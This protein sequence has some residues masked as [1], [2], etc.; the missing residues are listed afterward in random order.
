MARRTIGLA[1][2]LLLAV[3]LTVSIPLGATAS[4]TI[5]LTRVSGANRFLT[6]VAISQAGFPTAGSAKVVVLASGAAFADALA[7]TPLAVQKGG[8]LLLTPN[9]GLSAPVAAEITRVLPPGGTVYVLGG[10]T[11]LPS[12]VDAQLTAM[13][14]TPQRLA[15][16]TRYAT[17]VA[18]AGA[19]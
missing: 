17:A 9:T 11:V 13:G 18:I 19:M 15:G 10:T 2:A 5:A 7:G 4:G 3:S 12:S 16:G 1:S 14:F 8:P 6:S